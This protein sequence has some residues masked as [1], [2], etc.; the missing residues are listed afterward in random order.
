MGFSKEPELDV[1]MH[2]RELAL[3]RIGTISHH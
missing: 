2:V 3:S 1:V